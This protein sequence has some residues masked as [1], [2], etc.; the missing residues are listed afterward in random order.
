VAPFAEEEDSL[1]DEAPG[2]NPGF[3]APPPPPPET[4]SEIDPAAL[5]PPAPVANPFLLL[6]GIVLVVMEPGLKTTHPPAAVFEPFP[7][8]IVMDNS[9]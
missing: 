6:A 5:V 7:E 9:T 8:S 4:L 3:T 2:K 1:A